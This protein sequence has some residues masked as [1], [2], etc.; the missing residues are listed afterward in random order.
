MIE[1]KVI[2]SVGKVDNWRY[3][4]HIQDFNMAVHND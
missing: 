4:N 2:E 3:F 1:L